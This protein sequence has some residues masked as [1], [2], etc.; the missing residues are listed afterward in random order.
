MPEP[1]DINHDLRS[2]I[3]SLRA[4]L[5]L[6]TRVLL[7]EDDPVT[8]YLVRRTLKDICCFATAPTAKLGI[9]MSI[10]FRPDIL[11][12]D[13]NLPDN[14]GTHVLD[15]IIRNSP[16]TRVI[17]FTSIENFETIDILLQTGV[18][19]Y[20]AKPFTCEALLRSI[21]PSMKA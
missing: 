17:I 21:C 9:Y 13:L 16:N 14:Y 11:I 18:Q 1:A 5:Q 15:W 6:N 7:V 19:E 20:L 8:R 12:L 4:I 10:A 3:E 2:Q